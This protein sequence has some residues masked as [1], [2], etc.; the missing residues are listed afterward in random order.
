M[1]ITGAGGTFCA[2][3]LD[4]LLRLAALLH[5]ARTA[6]DRRRGRPTAP[7]VQA[8]DPA[9]RGATPDRAESSPAEEEAETSA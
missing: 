3:G 1:A 5:H 8:A 6:A 2:G 4:F 7:S 9:L